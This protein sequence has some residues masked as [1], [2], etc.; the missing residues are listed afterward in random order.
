M[1]IWKSDRKQMQKLIEWYTHIHTKE[2]AGS[3]CVRERP[4][5]RITRENGR[6]KEEGGW[7]ANVGCREGRRRVR[8]QQ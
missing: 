8:M 2:N 4:R 6:R 3:V 1:G 7:K 5:N